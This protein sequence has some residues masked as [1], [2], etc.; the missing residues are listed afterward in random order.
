M[1]LHGDDV[2]V[3]TFIF[4]L[5]QTRIAAA[6]YLPGH[7]GVF[8]VFPFFRRYFLIRSP[9]QLVRFVPQ[10][11]KVAVVERCKAAVHVDPYYPVTA[12][13]EQV[14]IIPFALLQGVLYPV[15][16]ADVPEY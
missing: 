10:H 15:L 9:Q 11:L 8:R 1:Q 3:F 5:I 4:F 12:V 14:S 6:H 2:P 13:L 16:L 7:D